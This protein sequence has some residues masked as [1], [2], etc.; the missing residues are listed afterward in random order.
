MNAKTILVLLMVAAMI[1]V[2]GCK[3]SE[4]VAAPQTTAS[5]ADVEAAKAQKVCPVMGSEPNPAI[6][7][8]YKG[9]KVYFCCPSCKPEFE[10][11]PEKYI[12]KLPQFAK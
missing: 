8:E 12:G 1:V 10:K 11:N 6:C 2:Y 9:K 4:P 5:A 3:K 7:T